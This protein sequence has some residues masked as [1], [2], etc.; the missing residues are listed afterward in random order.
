MQFIPGCV[1]RVVFVCS[2]AAEA[3][4]KTP[5]GPDPLR[6]NPAAPQ[7]P[8][9]GSTHACL[10]ER[11]SAFLTSHPFHCSTSHGEDFEIVISGYS[12]THICS[13]LWC[14]Q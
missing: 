3:E 1:I 9:S 4:E 5:L 7:Q 6:T 12:N 2:E 8:Y 14:L 13:D 10:F 11:D